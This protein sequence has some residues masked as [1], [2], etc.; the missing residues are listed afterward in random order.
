LKDKQETTMLVTFRSS[1]AGEM[2]MMSDA[3]RPLL[4]AIGKTCAARGV[5]DKSEIPLAVEI[6][7][8]LVADAISERCAEQVEAEEAIAKAKG[9]PIPVSIAQRAW[10]FIQLLNS[11]AQAK[12][13]AH[14][15]WE[16]LADFDQ[17]PA[18]DTPD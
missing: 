3:A 2:L 8:R 9:K 6:L 18:D 11:T 14:I 7:E 17:D 5:I 10:P 1:E 15:V 13:A 16:A 12:K 4:L